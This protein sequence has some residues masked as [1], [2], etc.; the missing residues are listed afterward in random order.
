MLRGVAK[1][2]VYASLLP[3][4]R[5]GHEEAGKKQQPEN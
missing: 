2:M 1:Q 4:E 5:Q 3:Q